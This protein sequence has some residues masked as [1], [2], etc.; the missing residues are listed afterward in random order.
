MSRWA[1]LGFGHLRC[2]LDFELF[3]FLT[4]VAKTVTLSVATTLS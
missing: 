3:I 1:E 2:G 4:D